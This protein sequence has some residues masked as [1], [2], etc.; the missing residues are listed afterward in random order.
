MRLFPKTD[1]QL[2]QEAWAWLRAHPKRV[3]SYTMGPD[4]QLHY[5][6]YVFLQ[7]HNSHQ[8]ALIEAMQRIAAAAE[9]AGKRFNQMMGALR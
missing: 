1:A 7:L 4:G 5:S 2:H 8:R 9:E 6:A 3:R